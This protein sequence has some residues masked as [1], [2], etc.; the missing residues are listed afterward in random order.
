MATVTEATK[1]KFKYEDNGFCRVVFS[2]KRDGKNFIY[3]WQEDRKNEFTF[4]RCTAGSEPSH[5]VKE[6]GGFFAKD[7]TPR[8]PAKTAVGISLNKFLGFI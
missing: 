6:V 1:L 8:N 7:I 3:C 5:E 4:Y 2:N